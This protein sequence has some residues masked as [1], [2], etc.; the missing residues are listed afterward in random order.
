MKQRIFSRIKNGL[1]RIHIFS[2]LALFAVTIALVSVMTG[3]LFFT[4]T[5]HIIDKSNDVAKKHYTLLSDPYSI[6]MEAGVEVGHYDEV[7][8]T[9][10]VDYT[11]Y[12]TIERAH[13]VSLNVD[14]KIYYHNTTGTTVKQILNNFDVS[15]GE[16]DLVNFTMDS[17]TFEGMEIIVTRVKFDEK[18][19]KSV[20]EH[21]FEQVENKKLL[22]GKS[23]VVTEGKDGE[24]TYIY[25]RKFVN[26]EI[27]DEMLISDK[28]T[29]EPITEVVENGTYVAPKVEQKI[30]TG[31]AISDRKPS[32]NVK[33]TEKGIPEKYSKVITGK[34]TSYIAPQ[35]ALT[36]TGRIAQVGVVAVDPKV[37]PYG[38]ELYIVSK[39]GKTVYGYAIA[40]D[41]G[42]AMRSG[43]ILVDVFV[44]TL[45][46]AT[47]WGVRQ[48]NVYVL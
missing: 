42:G 25:Q 35:G 12:I 26:G 17:V 28:I 37:I 22:K 14:G 45:S 36:S 1:S 19:V 43:R 41:T 40:G 15:L 6:L 16:H 11:T 20:I 10:F 13:E 2:F 18:I 23:N 46:M 8:Y 33:L 44:P 24:R 48:V 9:D 38:S 32:N 39:D 31:K 34:A 27:T 3:S 29:V 5:A 4:N 47:Q 21:D 7:S 30:V